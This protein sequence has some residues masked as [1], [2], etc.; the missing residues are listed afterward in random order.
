MTPSKT[1]AIVVPL[2]PRKELS[3]E[4]Q[5]SMTHLVHFLGKYDTYLVVPRSLDIH[6]PGFGIKR[7]SDK[8]FGSPQAYC[9][10]MLS[11]RFYEAFTDYEYVL[12]Y[13]LDCLVFSDELLQWCEKGLDYIGP[14]WLNCPDSPWVEVER[15]G[16]GGFSL[17]KVDSF[18]KVCYSRHYAIEPSEYWKNFC[19]RNPAYVQY[20]HYPKKYLKRLHVFNGARQQMSRWH[21]WRNE[22]FFWSDEA[23]RYYP[24]FKVAAVDQG[25]SFGFEVAPRRCFAM[26]NHKL[27]FGCHAWQRYDREFW[28]PYL[29]GHENVVRIG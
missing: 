10:L 9:R 26:N 15:V 22:D 24:E 2:S 16:N 27:P 18:L 20:L 23:L 19:S 8:Y 14:P 4:E 12:N 5:I 6:Y 11:P 25:V 28:E 17:R 3:K 21:L 7:F 1:V 13:H 29:L